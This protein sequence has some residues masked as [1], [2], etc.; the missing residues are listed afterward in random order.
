ME[1]ATIQKEAKKQRAKS[2]TKSTKVQ[3][4]KITETQKLE[5]AKVKQEVKRKSVSEAAQVKKVTR[6][7]KKEVPQVEKIKVETAPAKRQAST[8]STNVPKEKFTETKKSEV[9]AEVI[10]TAPQIKQDK[11]INE[12][13]EIKVSKSEPVGAPVK[14]ET[15]RVEKV[16]AVQRARAT[17]R[18]PEGGVIRNT[19]KSMNSVAQA[20]ADAKIDWAA[21]DA[22]RRKSVR[23]WLSE[24]VTEPDIVEDLSDYELGDETA[25]EDSDDSEAN[26]E[27]MEDFIEYDYED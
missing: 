27:E 18:A 12:V 9:K 3:K 10:K 14:V 16:R 1:P 22:R 20:E 2:A 23:T 24:F 5:E 15:S 8:K 19:L 17:P 21:V 25:S 11:V 26:R 7:V 4:E 13:K 6:G